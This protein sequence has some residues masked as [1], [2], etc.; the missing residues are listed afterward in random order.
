M[1]SRTTNFPS[2]TTTG[3]GKGGREGATLS[4][5]PSIFLCHQRRQRGPFPF[6]FFFLFPHV[7]SNTYVL[8]AGIMKLLRS[9]FAFLFSFLFFFLFFFSIFA[10][11]DVVEVSRSPTFLFPL[12]QRHW[13]ALPVK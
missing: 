7:Q 10:I 12:L 1:S 8:G 11:A 5:T 13:L 2:K 6:P 9:A 3:E 4:I